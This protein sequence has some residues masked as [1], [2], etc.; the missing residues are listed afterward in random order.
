MKKI[1]STG[2]V[3][4]MSLAIV[5][6]GF[7]NEAAASGCKAYVEQTRNAC[8]EMIRRGLDVSCK[9][10]VLAIE[11]AMRQAQGNLFDAGSSGANQ[12]V[13]ESICS[14]HLHDLRAARAVNQASMLPKGAAGPHCSALAV[15]IDAGC[16][17]K[18][19][20]APLARGCKSAM[21]MMGSG[22]AAQVPREQRCQLAAG[23][24]LQP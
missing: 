22:V 21:T 14:S 6:C 15:Q 23:M 16:L 13:A 4:L 18:L 1:T 10:Q 12:R 9:Q 19:G 11:M 24:L 17:S 3:L 2:A 7:A 20:K 8:L 5:A